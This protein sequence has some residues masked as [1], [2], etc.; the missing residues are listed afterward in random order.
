MKKWTVRLVSLALVFTAVPVWAADDDGAEWDWFGSLRAR[1]EYNENLSDLAAGL[2]DKIGYISYRLNLG[3][4]VE[5]DKNVGVHVDGQFLGTFGEDF[6]PFRGGLS[7][8]NGV[9]DFNLFEAYVGMNEMFDT[10]FSLKVGRQK[11]VF[12]DEWL[13]GDYDFYGGTSHDGF[14]G[15]FDTEL[16][17]VVPFWVKLAENDPPEAVV[18]SPGSP[19][20]DNNGDFDAYAVW[21]VW[22]LPGDQTLDTGVVY[23]LNRIRTATAPFTDKRWTYAAQ[24][25]YGAATGLQVD[26]NAAIQ[27][28]S[29]I[30]PADTKVDIDADAI[31]ATLGW[32]FERGGGQ[33]TIWAR[34]ANYTG[35]DFDTMDSEGFQ[36]L[37]Q[38]T[39]GRYGYL[40]IWNGQWG[41]TNYLYG[42][43]I[44]F[45][46]LGWDAN[47]ANGIGI[48]GIVQRMRRTTQKDAVLKGR[49]L[50]EEYGFEITY[51]YGDNV[52]LALGLAQ[53]YPG[54]AI[55][56]EPPQ[57]TSSTVRRFYLNTV[58]RF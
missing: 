30:N 31:E 15:M 9:S 26:V 54:D 35:D 48:R 53:L 8:S 41:F 24:Y 44:Q 11:V 46:Q 19:A 20:V 56:Y 42:E 23:A 10:P 3:F 13:F 25:A 6:T 51:D 47:L 27:W 36:P 34:F 33:Y 21:T 22:N 45:Q 49:N 28:G 38:D 16:V 39:H 5:L 2:D 1:P 43:G 18:G 58:T 40:D 37:F 50:G 55:T 57:F 32:A 12:A 29:T 17:K 52:E 14:V 7:Q 4:D